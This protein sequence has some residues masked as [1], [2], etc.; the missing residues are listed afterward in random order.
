MTVD[1]YIHEYIYV[2]IHMYIYK[3]TYSGLLAVKPVMNMMEQMVGVQ[4]CHNIKM[5][6]TTI[7]P[8]L[9]VEAKETQLSL[10]VLTITDVV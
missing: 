1:W 5:R 4:C 8:I 6:Y 2:Y 3:I 7:S 10:K 9:L